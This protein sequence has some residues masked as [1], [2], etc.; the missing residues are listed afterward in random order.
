MTRGHAR[1]QLPS[2]RLSLSTFGVGCSQFGGLYRANRPT[3]PAEVV[4]AAWDAGLRYFDTA[5][6]YGYGLSEHLL[7]AAL[8]ERPRQEFVLSTKVGRL[9]RPDAGVAAGDDGWATP[10][11]FRPVYDYS[12][13]GVMRS[14]EDSLQRLGVSRIDMLFVHDIGRMTHGDRHALHW[15]ALTRDGGFRALAELRASGQVSSIGLGVNEW[16]VVLD[17]MNELDLDCSLLAG[18]YSLLDQTSLGPLLDTC[19]R[20]GHAIVLGA[21]FNSGVLAGTGRFD[22]TAA[23]ASVLA[24]AE[25]LAEACR[26]FEVPLPAAALQ[27]PL[28]HPAVVCV[29]PGARTA[30]QLRQNLDWFELPLPPELWQSLRERRLIDAA[31]PVPC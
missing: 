31:A 5:P 7:G 29:L 20:Q 12:Y 21:P 15:N 25:A 11:P 3:D 18:R 17:A 16:E 30:A 14:F 8:R 24:R 23:P 4:S 13:S 10:L 26:A 1:R 28:A 9:L 19:A 22:Y 6:F 27:F 2:G